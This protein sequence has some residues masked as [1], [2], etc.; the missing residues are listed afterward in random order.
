MTWR[1]IAVYYTLCVVLGGYYF[2]FERRPDTDKPIFQ[3]RPVQQ[4]QF[5]PIPRDQIRTLTLRRGAGVVTVQRNEH[6]WHVIEPP[7]AAVTSALVTS[8]VES[9]TVDKEI[10]VVDEAPGDLTPYGLAPPQS[11]ITIKG[12]KDNV[13][14]TVFLGDRNPTATA[15]Y[16]R[17]DNSPEVVLLGFSVKYY[18]DLIFEAA[19]LQQKDGQV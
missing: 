7:G 15:V 19:G 13:L 3:Q 10:Q 9:L 4:S 2:L 17:K 8:L 5:L 6:G 16:A 1:R 14:T 11:E 12:A 18:G